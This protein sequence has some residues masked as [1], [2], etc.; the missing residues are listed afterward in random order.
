[1]PDPPSTLKVAAVTGGMGGISQ[2]IVIALTQRDFDVV[3]GDRTIDPAIAERMTT[4]ATT[5]TTNAALGARLSFIRNDLA[6][7]G[8]LPGSSMQYSLPS[9]T[10]FGHI[11]RLVNNTGLPAK[12]RG[13][14]FDVSAESYDLRR[15]CARCVLPAQ[16]MLAA[17]ADFPESA[18]RSMRCPKRRSPDG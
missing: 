9:F 17:E 4:N 11:E 6:D 15:E 3:V 18:R 12:S 16:A 13:E 10:A 8:D 1:M 7:P 5:N 2:G 14:L